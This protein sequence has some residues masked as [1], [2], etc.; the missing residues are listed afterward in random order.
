MRRH[1]EAGEKEQSGPEEGGQQ[2]ELCK[3]EEFEGENARPGLG[4]EVNARQIVM[5]V[6]EE[7]KSLKL[8]AVWE[9]RFR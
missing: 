9:G 8:L 5:F 3:D 7:R 2:G 4:W 1:Q 6:K